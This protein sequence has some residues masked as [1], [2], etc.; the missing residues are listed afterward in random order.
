MV[1]FL[2]LANMYDY[3]NLANSISVIELIKIRRVI[4]S[5]DKL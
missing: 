4:I 3:V 5:I 1:T 2:M